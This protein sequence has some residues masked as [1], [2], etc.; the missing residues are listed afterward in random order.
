MGN[1]NHS[2]ETGRFESGS[3]SAA[4]VGDHSKTSPSATTRNVEGHGNLPRSK[5]IAKHNH[6]NSVGT[7]T[8][9]GGGG[10]GQGGGGGHMSAKQER[11]AMR[12]QVDQ[13]HMPNRTDSDVASMTAYGQPLGTQTPANKLDPRTYDRPA[14]RK[15]LRGLRGE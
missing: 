6:A 7:S 5:V 15:Y 4:A 14:A 11:I 12:K 13:R 1:P 9:G 2:S 3:A 8:G 10:G